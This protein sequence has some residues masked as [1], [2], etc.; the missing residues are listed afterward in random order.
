MQN[1]KHNQLPGMFTRSF[2]T[3]PSSSGQQ[4]K[5]EVNKS[6]AHPTPPAINYNYQCGYNPNQWV[7]EEFV[8]TPGQPNNSPGQFENQQNQAQ[9]PT[10]QA[11]ETPW[12]EAVPSG[13]EVIDLTL[14]PGQYGDQVIDVRSRDGT[15]HKVTVPADLDVGDQLQIRINAPV[16][17]PMTENVEERVPVPTPPTMEESALIQPPP[18]IEERVPP[19]SPCEKAQG[20]LAP[21][22]KVE[23]ATTPPP[24]PPKMKATTAEA[25]GMVIKAPE[26]SFEQGVSPP[27][28][29]LQNPPERIEREPAQADPVQAV[30]ANG[31]ANAH[32]VATNV[33][34]APEGANI[35]KTPDGVTV[36]IRPD[37]T[38]Q[39]TFPDGTKVFKF[40]NGTKTITSPDGMK[41][42]FLLDGTEK[43]TF[44]DG[45]IL[46][47][48]RDGSQIQFNK[49]GTIL[50]QSDGDILQVNPNGVKYE[51]K[52]DGTKASH[53]PDGTTVEQLPDGTKIKKRF[54]Y[55]YDP[56]EVPVKNDDLATGVEDGAMDL[57]GKNAVE[58]RKICA[59]LGI[60]IKTWEPEKLKAAINAHFGK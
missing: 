24:K 35:I 2:Q 46:I 22:P 6:T 14:G 10:Q 51:L 23:K 38:V 36:E 40:R 43:Q 55:A 42:E 8:G 27:V 31:D 34:E 16:L 7:K 5:Y 1:A 32:W 58:L 30:A 52:K 12:S 41:L 19:V 11:Q 3:P 45:T 9:P 49:D 20:A 37:G 48:K 50:E 13:C 60:Q 4:S 57:T 17:Q 56:K 28:V 53:R 39:T 54:G 25:S 18:K 47:S 44:Q 21:L 59:L 33:I 29:P 15:I 26:A